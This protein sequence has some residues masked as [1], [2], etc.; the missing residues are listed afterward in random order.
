[1]TLHLNERHLAVQ[2]SPLLSLR[3]VSFAIERQVLLHPLSLDLPAGKSIALIGHNGSGKS[4]L[5]KLIGRQQEPTSG[6]ILFEGQSLE[7]WPARA[8][9]RRLAYLPQRTPAAPGMLVKELVAL[10]RYPWHG[11]LGR[12][13][14]A[15]RAKVEEAIEL[16]GIGAFADRMVDSL[17]GGERQRVW[18]AMLVAQDATCLLLDEPISALDIGHQLEVL[19]LTHDLCREK[20]IT[21]ITVLHDVNMAARFC[22]Q[23][24]ALHSGRLIANGRP[25]EVM[26]PEELARIYDVRMDIIHQPLSGRLVALAQ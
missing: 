8:F 13:S 9:A 6:K 12:F 15:D 23:I 26:T 18:L 4:T 19:Q 10:G 22:D 11:A 7:S 17:S 16:T 2:N 24:I 21:I 5:L 1:M 25:D 20:G 14:A 3:E